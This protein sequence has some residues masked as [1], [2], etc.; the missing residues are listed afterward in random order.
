MSQGKIIITEKAIECIIFEALKDCYGVVG[1]HQP[2]ILSKV[3][4]QPQGLSIKI[5][6]G[7]V[8]LRIPLIVD[9]QV[10]FQEVGRNTIHTLKYVLSRMLGHNKENIKVKLFLYKAKI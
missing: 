9:P 8:F 5:K 2:S 10:P 7:E 3:H 6:N 1:F 4:L